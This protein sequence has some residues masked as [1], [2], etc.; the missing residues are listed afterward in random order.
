MV[1]PSGAPLRDGTCVVPPDFAGSGP[2]ALDGSS[3]PFAQVAVLSADWSI[4]F[5]TVMHGLAQK[6][7][8]H[9]FL[10]FCR[11]GQL[12]YITKPK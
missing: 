11:L 5:N 4:S 6:F 2:A 7:G 3:G 10:P 12:H 8:Q 9:S 1:G